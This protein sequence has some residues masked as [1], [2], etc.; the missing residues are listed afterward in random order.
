MNSQFRYES[1]MPAAAEE[2]F[3]WH[4][5]P[6]AFPRMQPPW[7][8]VRLKSGSP[9]IE[10]GS[11]TCL[12]LRM[13]P[14]RKEWHALHEAWEPGRSFTDIQESGPFAFWRHRHGFEPSGEPTGSR[15]IDDIEYRLPLHPIS[16]PIVGSYVRGQ[17]NQLFQY[18]HAV[19]SRDLERHAQYP[20]TPL[21]IVISGA[22]GM[23]GSN[24]AAY[25]STAGHDVKVLRRIRGGQ[26]P[27][28]ADGITWSIRDGQI[29]ADGLEGVD[30]VIHLSG[31]PIAERW[32]EETK[33]KILRSRV[34]S[35]ELLARTF[36]EL[37]HPPRVWICASG[38]GWYGAT[39]DD[40]VRVEGD[41]IGPGF[42]ADVVRHWE[43]ATRVVSLPKTRIVN[44][45]L[46]VVLS[47]QGGAV[48]K[49][50]P[51]FRMGAGGPIGTGRQW[52]SWISLEDVLGA[53]EHCLHTE[54]VNGPVNFVS[55]NPLR[56]K[57]FASALGGVLS[58]PSFL[59]L[60]A[61]VVR[62]LF[63]K[64][65]EE[66][67]LAGVPVAPRRLLDSGFRFALPE[68]RDA[69]AETLGKRKN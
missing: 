29:D 3:D 12:E 64:M 30:A 25:L 38:A 26:R 44:M 4:S 62:I 36:A 23:L 61:A 16:S 5:R 45:R 46:G 27:S 35:T 68:A 33:A 59:P 21:R 17:L 41:P 15:L 56:Q 1:P 11:R 50:M 60:P 2:A 66:A 65:G 55:P 32:D 57:D 37:D 6:G 67:L 22:S 13:G 24:L 54:S 20:T 14:F 10:P 49:M 8:D 58:R 42:L 48:Q 28:W 34:E 53:V 31:S 52:M 18:R 69:L 47:A 7:Q 51:A 63:G 40:D 9:G 39:V 43:E 19:L